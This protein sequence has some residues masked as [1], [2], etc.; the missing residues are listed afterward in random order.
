MRDIRIQRGKLRSAADEWR[1]I[2]TD[3]QYLRS[4]INSVL[5]FCKQTNW[6]P[7]KLDADKA[8]YYTSKL[9]LGQAGTT[10]HLR[11][12]NVIRTHGYGYDSYK[13]HPD[14]ELAR[15][16]ARR[17]TEEAKKHRDPDVQATKSDV[18]PPQ[19]VQRIISHMRVELAR[20]GGPTRLPLARLVEYTV[21]AIKWD[22]AI[23]GTGLRNLPLYKY[24]REPAGATLSECR[25]WWIAIPDTKEVKLRGG[26]GWCNGARKSSVLKIRR[27]ATTPGHRYSPPSSFGGCETFHGAAGHLWRHTS[28]TVGTST[29]I[30]SSFSEPGERCKATPNG[31]STRTCQLVLYTS[32]LHDWRAELG[33]R[34]GSTRPIYGIYMPRAYATAGSDRHSHNLA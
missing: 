29:S 32:T 15:I 14:I 21:F 22:F 23:R 9:R 16:S 1:A 18:V 3:P 17:R 34:T 6:N 20:A 26:C 7:A 28:Y 8:S 25:R 30:T 2:S 27:R 31:V 10:K 24:R 5:R 4:E 13:L 19:D 12:I 33:W 11:A